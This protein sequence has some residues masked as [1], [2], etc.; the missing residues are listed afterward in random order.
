MAS[1]AVFAV[2]SV[3]T[4]RVMTRPARWLVVMVPKRFACLFKDTVCSW[5]LL[6]GACFILLSF[7][8]WAVA[9]LIAFLGVRLT[10]LDV[11]SL[12]RY[13]SRCLALA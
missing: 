2:L 5:R 9:C 4:K 12:R 3:R 11:P 1:L 10:M 13:L 7:L 6:I 8:L